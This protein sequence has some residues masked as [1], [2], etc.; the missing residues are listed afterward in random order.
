MTRPGDEPAPLEPASIPIW[1]C[2][3]L[4]VELP[5]RF[6]LQRV[7]ATEPPPGPEERKCTDG[8][9]AETE[10]VEVSKKPGVQVCQ[11]VRVCLFPGG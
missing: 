8:A 2:G 11:H 3:H 4:P 9:E 10:E 1:A 7:E 5:R 6:N